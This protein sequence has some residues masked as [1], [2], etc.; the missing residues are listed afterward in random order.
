[1]PVNDTAVRSPTA[2][3]TLPIVDAAADTTWLAE[4]T[5]T[6]AAQHTNTR[7][8]TVDLSLDEPIP[9]MDAETA[10]SLDIG[11]ADLTE[12]TA[13]FVD[14]TDPADDRLAVGAVLGVGGMGE[15]LEAQQLNLRRSVAIKRALPEV[16]ERGQRALLREAWIT[17]ALEHP[18]IVPVHTLH[19]GDDGSPWLVMKKIDGQPWS[20]RIVERPEPGSRAFGDWLEAQ[21]RVLLRLCD[22]VRFAHSRGVLHRDLKPE[23]VL[24]GD[25]GEV[26]LADWG[27]AVSLRDDCEAHLPRASLSRQ[28]AGTPAYMAPEQVRGEGGLLGVWTDVYLLGAILYEVLTGDPPHA[29]GDVNA[30]LFHAWTSPPVNLPP[31]IPAPL[32]QIC[33]EALAREPEDRYGSVEAFAD[34]IR[35]FLK[36]RASIELSTQARVLHDEVAA[37]P[38]AEQ[39]RGVGDL[40]GGTGVIDGETVDPHGVHRRF[41]EARFGYR[42][43]LDI[44]PDNAAAARG[45]TELLTLMIDRDLH[46]G[47]L[48]QASL[49]YEELPEPDEA[50]HDRLRVARADEARRRAQLAARARVGAEHDAG[51]GI[52]NRRRFIVALALLWTGQMVW[53]GLADARG[54]LSP[55]LWIKMGLAVAV[56]S[57]TYAAVRWRQIETARLNRRLLLMATGAFPAI[58]MMR[59]V[60]ITEGLT[61]AQTQ[62]AELLI[63]LVGTLHVAANQQL[64]QVVVPPLYLVFAGLMLWRPA[65]TW[66]LAAAAHLLTFGGLASM[67]S[68]VDGEGGEGEKVSGVEFCA[69]DDVS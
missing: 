31:A 41:A 60:L 46:A 53:A 69:L 10:P 28:I 38:P 52:R 51:V 35:S 22:A 48:T 63:F 32:R 8:T 61:P 56:A 43:A 68:R 49:L 19:R 64:R 15:V 25:F 59:Y 11:T 55:A 13:G 21:L 34:A 37:I 42:Q 7:L 6:V 12:I 66:W 58:A 39:P 2:V 26:V 54:A 44:W 33:A 20:D 36:H 29:S 65:W 62:P 40:D 18:H 5:A 50:L 57:L 45:L 23:N 17:G 4:A 3:A 47:E 1:M 30:A 67:G 27:I 9:R 24:V 16:G 14:S